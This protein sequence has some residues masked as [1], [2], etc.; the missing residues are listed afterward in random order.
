MKKSKPFFLSPNPLLLSVF[1]LAGF[2]NPAT[3]AIARCYDPWR[4]PV[5]PAN[6][7]TTVMTPASQ[8]VN[9]LN[10]AT[11][12]A[13]PRDISHLNKMTPAQWLDEQF[14]MDASCHLAT[15]NQTQNNNA[16]ENRMEVWFRLSVT[17]PDQLRQ[18]VAFALSEIFV[19]SD[20]GSGI[21]AN[22]MAVYYDILVRNAF[23]NFRSILEEVTLSP[24]M[25]RYLSMLGNQKPNRAKGI[26]ADENYAREIM[27]LFS[28]GLVKL[29]N[30]GVPVLKNGVTIPTYSQLDVEGLARTFTGWSWGNSVNFE[31]GDDWRVSM[32]PFLNYH[33]RAEK[34][35]MTN[36][37][38]PAA[39]TPETDLALALNTIFKHPNVGP[40]IARRLIQRLVTSNPS[41]DYI[42]RVATAFN[43]NGQGVRGDMKAVIRAILLDTEALTGKKANP[44]FGKLR[45]PLIALT[46]LWRAF[47]GQA[48]DGRLPYYYPESYIIQAPLSAPSVFNFFKPD[49][50][51][52]RAFS[53]KNLVA[54]EFQL[55]NEANITSFQNALYERI[56]W[57]YK[58]KHNATLSSVLININ[59]LTKKATVAPD[60]VNYLDLILTGNQMPD[61]AKTVLINYL[62]NVPIE[63]GDRKGV[64][65]ATD[66]LYLVMS[67]PYYLIQR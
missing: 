4:A 12:G 67:S 31:D 15:L 62:R 30:T 51:P 14:A 19:V 6:T 27:Q 39:G 50:S 40:F 59:G 49:Y 42:G 3:A 29:D 43:N 34:T 21:P 53:N 35:I 7:G 54:P 5:Y 63:S 45:E 18:R 44:N 13:N 2:S 46:H 58:Q 32:K 10:R 16:R 11:F 1:L 52:S 60:L 24:A 47:D 9:F 25:G 23:G 22:A 8:A 20:F 61:T 26:R 66:A 65:R 17:A 28:L 56:Q 38:L 36:K 48:A 64:R 55:I 33:D 37:L 57:Y 41:P